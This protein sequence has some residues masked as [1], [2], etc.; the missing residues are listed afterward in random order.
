MKLKTVHFGL[1][2]KRFGSPNQHFVRNIDLAFGVFVV[3]LFEIGKSEVV[4]ESEVVL[5]GGFL[6]F[7]DSHEIAL[8]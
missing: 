8:D 7:A 3:L 4:G 5:L 6:F 2:Y 1:F